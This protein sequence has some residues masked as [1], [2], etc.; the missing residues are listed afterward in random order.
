MSREEGKNQQKRREKAIGWQNF[1]H[2]LI[3]KILIFLIKNN[4]I[5]VVSIFNDVQED[6]SSLE[7]ILFWFD[8]KFFLYS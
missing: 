4:S 8:F 6:R 3:T 7:K 5:K 1:S 2:Q